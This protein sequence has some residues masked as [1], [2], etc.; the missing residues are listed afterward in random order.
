M[1]GACLRGHRHPWLAGRPGGAS[2]RGRW[3]GQLADQPDPA[4]PHA[5]SKLLCTRRD[6]DA[7]RHDYAQEQPDAVSDA[8]AVAFRQSVDVGNPCGLRLG[9]SMPIADRHGDAVTIAK[10]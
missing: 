5:R 8:N 9:H 3:Q 2:A 6:A 4:R 7:L 1:G 10:R